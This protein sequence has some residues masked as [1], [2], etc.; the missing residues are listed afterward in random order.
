M[1]QNF[2][3]VVE[4]YEVVELEFVASKMQLSREEVFLNQRKSYADC[5]EAVAD[6]SGQEVECESGP[7]KGIA[8][9]TAAVGGTRDGGED[10]GDDRSAGRGG[11]RAADTRG[12]V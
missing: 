1:E 8:S 9:I 3:K 6:D 5:A 7:G 10:G 2:L 11:G 12:S 4:P